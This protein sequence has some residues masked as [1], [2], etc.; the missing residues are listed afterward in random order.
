MDKLEKLEKLQKLKECGAIT[1]DEF[2]QEKKK[3]LADDVEVVNNNEIKED[4]KIETCED[5][6]EDKINEQ[7]NIE[8]S[9]NNNVCIKCGNILFEEDKFCGKCGNKVSTDNKKVIKVKFNH[10]L[11]GII[12]CIVIVTGIIFLNK[13]EKVE[14]QNLI[15]TTVEEEEQNKIRDTIEQ[16]AKNIKYYNG[17]AI[18]YNSYSKYKVSSKGVQV[19]KIKYSTSWN[20]GASEAYY[21]QL[22]SLD[23]NN[24][25]VDTV[26]YLYYFIK[27][28]TNGHIS[29]DELM[30]EYA[31]EDG[32]ES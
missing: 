22:V 6:I 29:G 20:S 2:E 11:I 23:E 9:L 1:T 24:E 21:E 26:T 16:Y 7:A 3:I 31:Y 5:S 10:L 32:W 8:T 25:T 18:K 17:D 19:Y 13:P 30:V 4:I 28:N 27:S 14:V 12:I 15:G